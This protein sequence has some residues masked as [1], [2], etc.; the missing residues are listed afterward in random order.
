MSRATSPAKIALIKREGGRC[1][2]IENSAALSGVAAQLARELDGHFLDQ[3]TYAERATDWRGNNNIA[4]STLTPILG[5][6]H[7]LPIV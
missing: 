2:L 3:F 4:E 7:P 5:E 1:H 6:P